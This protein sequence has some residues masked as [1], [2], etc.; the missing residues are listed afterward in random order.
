MISSVSLIDSYVL[1]KCF[2]LAFNENESGKFTLGRV[3]W[4]FPPYI[5]CMGTNFRLKVILKEAMMDFLNDRSLI[6]TRFDPLRDSVC[7]ATNTYLTLVWS[8]SISKDSGMK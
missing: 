8:K 7:L 6:A 4:D 1:L 5:S 2:S 3:L